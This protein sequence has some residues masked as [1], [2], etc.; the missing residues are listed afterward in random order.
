MVIGAHFALMSAEENGCNQMIESENILQ[1]KCYALGMDKK[2][3]TR[4]QNDKYYKAHKEEICSGKKQKRLEKKSKDYLV[5]FKSK[6]HPEGIWIFSRDAEKREKYKILNKNKLKFHYYGGSKGRVVSEKTR[7]KI[8]LNN[9]GKH[10]HSLEFREKISNLHKGRVFSE[11]HK[12]KLSEYNKIRPKKFGEDNSF[13][14]KRHSVETIEKI[15]KANIGRKAPEETRKKMSLVRR[16][17]TF[18]E[19][20]K[21]KISEANKGKIVSENTKLKMVVTMS[22]KEYRENMS[23]RQKGNK[24][25]LGKKH[26]DATKDKIRIA[27]STPEM[28][29]LHCNNIKKS[30]EKMIKNRPI[31]NI[32]KKVMSQLNILG[33]RYIFQY[34]VD[35][36]FF[37]DF[38]ILEKGI[39]IE[40]DGEYWHNLES[41]K[42]RDSEKDL[43][44]KFN[45]L[46]FVQST[47]TPA[48]T[49]AE[50]LLYTTASPKTLVEATV[51]SDATDSLPRSFALP[52]CVFP[53]AFLNAAFA[54][55]VSKNAM[56]YISL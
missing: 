43:A 7:A 27:H 32:E 4:Q 34:F 39:L 31:T 40:C 44:A 46:E 16:G 54:N 33:E 35:G 50:G 18:S 5:F 29:E 28:K 19:E 21:K 9:L 41:A 1:E 26:S 55:V 45:E 38:F 25:W 24:H 17:R 2:E 36:R 23:Q 8:S 22:T 20:H 14:G 11:E 13:F 3:Y 49:E 53:T 6:R 15:R 30:I 37:Y 48:V 47:A 42:I 51:N 12:R 56:I 10:E 52:V